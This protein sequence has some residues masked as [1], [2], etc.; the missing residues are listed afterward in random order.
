MFMRSPSLGRSLSMR[1]SSPFPDTSAIESINPS[2]R[3]GS[4]SLSARTLLTSLLVERLRLVFPIM[5]GRPPSSSNLS[6]S[7]PLS[8][9]TMPPKVEMLL[10]TPLGVPWTTLSPSY[11]RSQI[12]RFERLPP[13]SSPTAATMATQIAADDPRPAAIGISDRTTRSSPDSTSMCSMAFE[14]AT[15]RAW[16]LLPLQVSP[17]TGM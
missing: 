3:W 5:K 6:I 12:S 17:R 16:S 14:A 4:L 2:T 13:C 1:A 8:Y 10:S 11:A 9:F 7:A 15:K